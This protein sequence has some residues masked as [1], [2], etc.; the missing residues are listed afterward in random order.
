MYYHTLMTG[1]PFVTN[2]IT[3]KDEETHRATAVCHTLRSCRSE[4]GWGE[5]SVGRMVTLQ[6]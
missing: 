3:D 5:G 4:K 2:E 1:M 6:L